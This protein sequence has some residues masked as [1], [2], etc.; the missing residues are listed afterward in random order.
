MLTIHDVMRGAAKGSL[1]PVYLLVGAERLLIERAVGAIRRAVDEDGVAGFNTEI[2]DGKGLAAATVVAAARTLPMM[3]DK[4]FVWVRHVDAMTPTE[5]T[6]LA[7][8]FDDP[9]DTTS[10]VLSATK[11]DG[12]GKLAKAG[13]KKG[14]LTDA[15]PLRGRELRAFV[16][17]EAK[18]RGHV[19]APDAIETLIDAVGDDLAAI[20]DAVERLSLFVGVGQRIGTDEVIQCVTRVRVDSIW[21]LVDAIGLKDRRKGMAA[22]QSLLTDREPPLRLLS[23]AARQ[24]RIVARMREALA[25]GMSPQEAAKRAGAP[26]FKA[27]DLTASA[28]QFSAKSLGE[29]FQLIAEADIALKSSKRPP[30]TIL[31]DAVMALCAEPNGPRPRRAD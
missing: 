19:I 18:N 7:S 20:D 15:K 29:A 11:L 4:R 24:L 10:L 14:F 13:K 3:A 6:E 17:T 27:S 1:E 28:R 25:E 26:P 31:Q 12:R 23:M 5:Q 21:S 30:D 2:F 22:A 16:R 8:Y 9:N